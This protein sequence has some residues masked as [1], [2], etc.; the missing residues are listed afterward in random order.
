[1]PEWKPEI[2]RRL[3]PLKLAPTREAEIADELAQHLEDRYQELLATGQSEGPA[4]RTAIDELKGEDFLARNLRPVE[5][6]LYREPIAA[7]KDSSNFFAG[8]LQDLR[9]ALRMLHKS[10]GFTAVAILTLALGI[11]ANT[12]IFSMVK[13]ILLSALPYPQPQ[14][15]YSINEVIPQWS[16]F[17]PILPVNSGNFLLWKS[18][19]NAFAEMAA[20]LVYPYN[21][22]GVGLPRQVYVAQAS[23]E[24]FSLMGV[25]PRL[26]RLF[27]PLAE[28]HGQ[29]SEII[30]TEQLWEQVFH[31]DPEILGKPVSLNGSSY[32]V[33]GVLPSN[34]RFPEVFGHAPEL[35]MP[36]ELRG[37]DLVPGIGNFKY[38]VIARL[39]P[40]DSIRQALA[41]LNVVEAEIARKGDRLRGAAPGQFNLYAKLTPLRTMI[42]GPIQSALWILMAA[43]A[44]VLL[45]IC[46]NLANLM[47]ARNAG[48]SHE[49]AVRAALGASPR[50]LA[51]QFLT[52]GVVLSAAGAVLGLFFAAFGLGLLVRNAPVDI[53]RMNNVRIDPS[54]L[55]FTLGV[56]IIAALLFALLPA[57]RLRRIAP[58]EAL[59]SGRT[60]TKGKQTARLYT[61]LVVSE[62]ALCCVL[63]SGALLLVQSLTRVL[64]ANRWMEAEHVLAINLTVP[65]YQYKTVPEL[66]Q[67]YSRVSEKVQ[68]LPGVMSAGWVSKLPLLGTGWGDD[69]RFREVTP[70][71]IRPEGEFRFASRGYLRTI[72]IPLIQGRW[73]SSEDQGQD[74]AVISEN[75]ARKLLQGRNPI[76]LHLLWEN[77]ASRVIG[78]VGDVRTAAD[79]KTVFAV[80]APIWSWNESDETLVVRTSMDPRA[81]S[82]AIRNAIWSVNSQIAIPREELLKTIV[83]QAI[84]PRQYETFLGALLAAFAVLLAALGLYG[85]ISY[86]VKQSTHEIGVRIALGAQRRDILRLVLWHGGRLALLG[87]GIGIVAASLLTR[88]LSSLLFG[89]R[90]TDP[91]TFASVV[92]LLV[93]VALLA[94]YIPARRAMRV[95]P[96]VALRYE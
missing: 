92:I 88:L 20:I 14:Q 26:G 80:Y 9:Y 67:F 22:T 94:C 93:L 17:A 18:R 32:T 76:G 68:G 86:S 65:A 71:P 83:Q 24:F 36:L 91:L 41:Q 8:I 27:P 13:G 69:F 58:V 42:V 30:L 48:R 73:F 21:M 12:A 81:A 62:I 74:V 61:G 37:F 64:R 23:P 34:F 29:S 66:Y 2:L 55:W 16:G 19:C 60:A 78:V 59:R 47:L 72:G 4:F 45:I 11:G 87:V 85:V 57:L 44:F 28:A 89:I 35:F 43:A 40:R 49:I 39:K 90:P 63:L 82:S 33:V 50:R 46:A 96:M 56:S 25:Q 31:S 54:A 52:E 70:P 84:A 75:I 38:A 6:D 7:G 53:P 10:P 3:A 77:K 15:L 5:R 79:S 1:M 51:Q 95:D